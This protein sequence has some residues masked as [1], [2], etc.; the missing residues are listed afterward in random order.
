MAARLSLPR[1]MVTRARW[2]AYLTWA[3]HF[4]TG[5]NTLAIPRRL[6]EAVTMQRRA[7]QATPVGP[8]RAR[9]LSNLGN[10]L[11]VRFTVASKRTDIQESVTVLG[12]AV[13]MAR[14]VTRPAGPDT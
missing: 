5:L 1:R 7:V 10:A 8:R 14:A 3:S 9:F 13:A 2:A 6:D 12:E 11:R 4:I